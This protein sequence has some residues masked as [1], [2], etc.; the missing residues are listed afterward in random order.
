MSLERLDQLATALQ[1]LPDLL[2][3][4]VGEVVQDNAFLLEDDNTAQLAQGL[5][6]L[7]RDIRPEYAPLTVE[8]KQAK[9]QPRIV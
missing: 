8:I 2:T 1:R 9:G 4:A 6:S 5:D 3:A 7:G